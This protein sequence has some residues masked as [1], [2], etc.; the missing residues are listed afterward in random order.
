MKSEKL[1]KWQTGSLPKAVVVAA[2]VTASLV[3]DLCL[4]RWQSARQTGTGRLTT[5]IAISNQA[6]TARTEQI[7]V[8]VRHWREPTATLA[9]ATSVAGAAAAAGDDDSE[10]QT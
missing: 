6:S 4:C 1:K 3:L 10:Q 2:A 8:Q 9:A 5:R 7:R